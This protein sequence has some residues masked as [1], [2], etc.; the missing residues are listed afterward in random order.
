MIWPTPRLALL[1]L[2][3]AAVAVVAGFWGR[4]EASLLASLA[5]AAPVAWD[6]LMLRRRRVPE[7]NLGGSHQASL[8][9][10]LVL[11]FELTQASGWL[12]V[13]VDWPLGLGG[14]LLPLC[15]ASSL[16]FTMRRTERPCR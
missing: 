7:V 5:L 16:R 8:R 15:F 1:V 4:A 9:R 12:E 14:P 11:P 6:G 2:A 10:P 13:A 3:V